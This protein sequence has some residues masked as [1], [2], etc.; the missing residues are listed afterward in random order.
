MDEMSKKISFDDKNGASRTLA[1]SSNPDENLRSSENL[2]NT[3]WN[4]CNTD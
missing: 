3:D 1:Q 4:L 2:C